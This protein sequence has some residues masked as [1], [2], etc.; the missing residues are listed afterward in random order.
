ML[1]TFSG[2]D[3]AGKSTLI[4]WLRNELERQHRPVVVLHLNDHVGVYAWAR[5]LR[6]RLFGGPPA[7][8]LP[9]MEPLPTRAG[10]VRDAILWSRTLR[11]VLYPIDLVVFLLVR[12]YLERVQ[13]RVLIMDR[14]FYDRLVDVAGH[15][16]RGWA[17]L[18][19][20]ARLTP[21]PDLPILLDI[22]PEEAFARKGEYTVAYLRRRQAAYNRVFPWVP[23]ALTLPA[24]APDL[25]RDAVARAVRERLS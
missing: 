14:Y 16:G 19:M 24:S 1:I 2:L 4:E 17:W 6:D 8:A 18:R 7:D 11:G 23:A 20:L 9:R 13:R 15:G 22:T 25:A 3:G 5:A 12:F 21:T 10:R